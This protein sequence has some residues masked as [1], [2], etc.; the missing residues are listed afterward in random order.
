MQ[1]EEFDFAIYGSGVD[2]LFLAAELIQRHSA[3]VLLVR[4]QVNDYTLPDHQDFSVGGNC[5]PD[6]IKLAHLGIERWQAQFSDRA[7]RSCF[8]KSPLNLK[9]SAGPNSDI[10][11]YIEGALIACNR[12]FERKAEREGA[13][14]LLLRDVV[15]PKK[16]QAIEFLHNAYLGVGMEVFDR[17]EFEDAKRLKD[18]RLSMKSDGKRYRADTTIILDDDLVHA[19]AN[20]ALRNILRPIQGTKLAMRLNTRF[21]KPPTLYV[22]G[23]MC[24]RQAAENKLLI[25]APLEFDQVI[26]RAKNEA[27]DLEKMKVHAM[28]AFQGVTTIDGGPLLDFQVQKKTWVF[29]GGT[30]RA[31]LM[32]H[33][34]DLVTNSSN[35]QNLRYWAEHSASGQRHADICPPYSVELGGGNARV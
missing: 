10:L 34:S 15:A 17:S 5:N 1:V 27:L 23:Q 16:R 32:P 26:S 30:V 21:V 12:Q 18:G 2:A 33:V 22:D 6:T 8:E 29:S 3:R 25:T 24:I 31:F 28:G 19:H 7:G 13:E 11:N 4:D 20:A 35:D 9:V 14:Y